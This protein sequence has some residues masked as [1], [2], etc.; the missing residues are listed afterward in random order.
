MEF[1]VT[2]GRQ[3]GQLVLERG[4][5]PP[6][7]PDGA[8]GLV[9]ALPDQPPDPVQLVADLRSRFGPVLEDGVEGLELER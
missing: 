9:E 2:V 8:P 6:A 3:P 7:G 1:G 5:G 4:A